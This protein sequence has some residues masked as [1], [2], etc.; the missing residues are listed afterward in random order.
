MDTQWLRENGFVKV[1]GRQLVWS[2]GNI[3]AI[4]REYLE[5][6][7]P[8]RVQFSASPAGPFK[9]MKPEDVKPVEGFPS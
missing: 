3:Y 7:N 6:D 2:R 4:H 1:D 9:W 5:S 8:E